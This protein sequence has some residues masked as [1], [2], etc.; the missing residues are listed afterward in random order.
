MAHQNC[1]CCHICPNCSKDT[2]V[3]QLESEP[4]S[5]D[6]CSLLSLLTA[7]PDSV[8]QALLMCDYT[9]APMLSEDDAREFGVLVTRNQSLDRKDRWDETTEP[10]T[11]KHDLRTHEVKIRTPV[12]D[13][14]DEQKGIED[15]LDVASV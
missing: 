7:Y 15:G 1:K 3:I 2:A 4:A 13:A 14:A 10:R 11:Q 9:P 5:D 12:D 6:Q 8:Y